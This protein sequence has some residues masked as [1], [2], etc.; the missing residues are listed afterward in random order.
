MLSKLVSLVLVSAITGSPVKFV[1]DVVTDQVELI[2][3]AVENVKTE[4]RAEKS[5][6]N[7]FPF[8][9]V[10]QEQNQQSFMPHRFLIH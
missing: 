3:R 4:N 8:N 10:K 7:T 1:F 6:L 2:N 9:S 5:L